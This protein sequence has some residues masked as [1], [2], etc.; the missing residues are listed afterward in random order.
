MLKR[1]FFGHLLLISTVFIGAC[2]SLKDF[3][4]TITEKKHSVEALKKDVDLS[5]QILKEGHPGLYWYI[6]KKQLDGKFDSLKKTINEPLTTAQFYQK[7]SPVIAAIRCGHTSLRY[8]SVV[9]KDKKEREAIKNKIYPLQQFTYAVVDEKLIIINNKSKD[10]TIKTGTEILEIDGLAPKEIFN[11]I[12]TGFSYDGY[13]ALS[14]N[15]RI[16]RSFPQLYK[17]YFAEQDSIAVKLKKD[18]TVINTYISFYDK[19]KEE[20]LKKKADT[21][22]KIA[23]TPVKKA[24]NYIK[25]RGNKVNDEYQLDF[26]FLDKEKEVAYMK[27]KSFSVPT[28]NFPLFYKQCFDSINVAKTKNLVIDIRNNPG[29]TLSASLAL[30]AYLTD[31]E[32]VYLDKPINNGRFNANKYGTGFQKL[33]YYLT[34]FND[35]NNLYEDDEGHF[36]SFMKGYSPQKARKDNYKGKVYV[37]INEFSFSA[38]SLLSANLKAI[39]RATFVGTETG[40]GAN[41]CT[42]GRIPVVTLKNSKL[43]LRFGLNRMAPVYQQKEVGRGVFPDVAIQSTLQDRISNYD[44]ELQWILTDIKGKDNVRK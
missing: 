6:S 40:G 38:S 16:E 12:S 25:H 30:F 21:V 31:K 9:Q 19:K 4:Y 24:P 42:A 36:F 28:A 23:K 27:I 17:I 1:R 26:K 18:T 10:K 37:L 34:G 35:D 33:T 3:N 8:P 43:G 14:R 32:F 11:I 13:N 7:L 22:K 29:G 2:S 39:N 41:Q 44:R 15:K 20:A 5:Y